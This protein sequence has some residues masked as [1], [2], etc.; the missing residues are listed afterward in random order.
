MTQSVRKAVV[1]SS[2]V[3]MLDAAALCFEERGY[4]AT[5]ID[6][7]ARR[8]EATKGR[9]YHHFH[10]KG[11]LF[12]AVFRHGMDMNYAV[13]EPVLA[14]DLTPMEKLRRMAKVHAI[15]MAR[16]KA[17]QRVVWEGAEMQMRSATTPEQRTALDELHK[18]RADFSIMFR[19]VIE[20]ARDAGDLSVENSSVATQLMFMALNSPIFWYSQRPGETE[21]DFERLIGQVVKFALRGLGARVELSQ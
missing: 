15:H 16:T 7:V 12:A 11:E 21:A 18:R 5:S 3:D 6:D 13:V 19:D 10:S 9:I 17:F 4:A 20:Q 1:E 14:L 8:L 2:R